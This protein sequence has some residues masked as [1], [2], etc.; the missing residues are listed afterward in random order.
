MPGTWR[1]NRR[2]ARS[3][4]PPAARARRRRLRR[5]RL[6][7]DAAAARAAL[8]RGDVVDALLHRRI[9]RPHRRP[10]EPLVRLAAVDGVCHPLRDQRRRGRGSDCEQGQPDGPVRPPR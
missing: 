2:R 4:A 1:R 7:G 10:V 8:L 3:R 6:R 9:E 5:R